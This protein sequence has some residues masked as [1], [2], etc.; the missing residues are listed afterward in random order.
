MARPGQGVI[1]IIHDPVDDP[2]ITHAALAAHDARRGQIVVHPTVGPRAA[3]IL[4]ADILTALGC[5]IIEST[6]RRQ[7]LGSPDA[8]FAAAA[9]WLLA[10]GIDLVIVLRAHR[11]TDLS[12]RWLGKLASAARLRVIAIWHDR[13]PPSWEEAFGIAAGMLHEIDD[14]EAALIG[15]HLRPAAEPELT[16]DKLP[17]LAA[18]PVAGLAGFRA[19]AYRALTAAQF[20]A[21]DAHYQYGLDHASA[22][23]AS[24]RRYRAV[25]NSA[26]TGAA[27]YGHPRPSAPLAAGHPFPTP[28]PDPIGLQEF[29]T[30]LSGSALTPSATIAR[31]RGAQAGMLLH[32]VALQVPAA[33]A[34]EVGPGLTGTCVTEQTAAAIRRELAH[35]RLA[36]AVAL[37]AV[38]GQPA[39]D[40][41]GR[42]IP[43]PSE[44]RSDL[45]SAGTGYGESPYYGILAPAQPLIDAAIH[46]SKLRHNDEG[47]LLAG[48]NAAEVR[49]AA[50]SVGVRLQAARAPLAR[51]YPWHTLSAAWIVGEPIAP[52]AEAGTERLETAG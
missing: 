32:G 45:I 48:F 52:A 16:A 14:L 18:M 31:V 43:I 50:K 13:R 24:H 46:F 36:A 42:P 34:V 44:H 23:L 51:R 4:A 8:M 30:R 26:P 28:W 33:L 17:E 2:E 47:H 15:A 49:S 6:A 12:R 22:W 27:A 38:T 41:M 35:P 29:L 1:T 19:E 10:D 37:T 7:H 11:L 3:G 25:L 39:E 9:S 40:V 21:V 5:H 20:A